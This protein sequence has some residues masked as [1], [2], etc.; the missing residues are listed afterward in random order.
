MCLCRRCKAFDGGFFS[1][2]AFVDVLGIFRCAA[3]V[4]D[5]GAFAI[6]D[7]IAEVPGAGAVE[8]EVARV[9][10]QLNSTGHVARVVEAVAF[11][12]FVGYG[13]LV[14]EFVAVIGV[15]GGD[16]AGEV[17]LAIVAAGYDPGGGIFVQGAV[18]LVL[19]VDVEGLPLPFFAEFGFEYFPGH[20]IAPVAVP[21]RTPGV[22][23]GFE[24]DAGAVEVGVVVMRGE[25]PMDGVVEFWQFT[26][27][28]EGALVQ[29]VFGDGLEALRLWAG[30]FARYFSGFVRDAA[31]VCE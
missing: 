29:V 19:V 14:A 20:V 25:D 13:F 16:F 6:G 11:L 17:A 23:G 31:Q 2:N 15:F 27:V 8:G 3:E 7:V 30:D 5:G 24:E 1:F 26:V 9:E 12:L 10:A 28:F 18:D 22:F 4:V 21:V